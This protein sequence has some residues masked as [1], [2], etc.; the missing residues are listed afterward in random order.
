MHRWRLSFL[1]ALTVMRYVDAEEEYFTMRDH[2]GRL[3]L[4]ILTA[5]DCQRGLFPNKLQRV[6]RPTPT[7][8]P[9]AS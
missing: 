5:Q 6:A 9:G 4:T 1:P 7:Q 2:G 3:T 8:L